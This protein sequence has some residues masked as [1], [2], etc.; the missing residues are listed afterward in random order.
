MSRYRDVAGF[1]TLVIVWGVGFAAAE[2]GFST[3]PPLLLNAFRYDLGAVLLFGYVVANGARWWP[4]AR[5]D[6][7]AIVSGGVLLMAIGNGV[8]FVGQDLTTSVFSGMMASLIPV[9]TVAFSWVFLPQDRLTPLSLVGFF[10]SF[11]GALVIT[12]PGSGFELDAGLVGKSIL[13]ASVCGMALGTV[14]IRR[15]EPSISAIAQTAWSVAVGAVLLHLLS[16][17][18]GETWHGA[19]TPASGFALL[20]LGLFNTVVVW[21]LY[22]TLL[23]RY[24]AI[25]MSLATYLVPVVAAAVGWLLF[26]ESVRPT[27]VTGFIVVVAGFLLMKRHA[28]RAEIH[29]LTVRT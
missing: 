10:V 13:F 14:L 26:G 23:E 5:G 12:L 18:V 9:T 29:R 6:V 25:E 3:F 15:A 8:W 17:L 16:P 28:L 7:L 1:A 2:I 19:V 27:M 22:F 11:V 21:L 4:T 24:S 20:F